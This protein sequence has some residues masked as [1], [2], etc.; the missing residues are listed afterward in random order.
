MESGSPGSRGMETSARVRMRLN[1]E[2]LRTRFQEQCQ[3]LMHP[4]T[5]PTCRN[6]GSATCQGICFRERKGQ[7]PLSHGATFRAGGRQATNSRQEKQIQ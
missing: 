6:G 2:S 4:L 7:R 3:P 5:E 1:E